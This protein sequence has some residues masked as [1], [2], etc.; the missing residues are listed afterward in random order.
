M[1]NSCDSM[2]CSHAPLSMGFSR[3]KWSGLPFPSL[4]DLLNPKTEPM[5]PAL[6]G[7]FSTPEP[8]VK[9]I[10]EFRNS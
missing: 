10:K 7:E 9:P 1:P 5:S 6:A 3:Q 4:G 8:P 2:D